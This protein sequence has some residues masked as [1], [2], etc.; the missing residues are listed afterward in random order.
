ME[1]NLINQ[2]SNQEMLQSQKPSLQK[3]SNTGEAP[4]RSRY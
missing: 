4:N 3:S 2:S 1:Q